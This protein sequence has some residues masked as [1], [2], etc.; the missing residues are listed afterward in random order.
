MQCNSHL[1]TCMPYS[2]LYTYYVE[3]C[4]R[5]QNKAGNVVYVYSLQIWIPY[6]IITFMDSSNITYHIFQH[7]KSSNEETSNKTS[8]EQS[9]H[10]QH[11]GFWTTL[12]ILEESLKMW[13]VHYSDGIHDFIKEN[14]CAGW[15]LTWDVNVRPLHCIGLAGD[16]KCHS[17]STHPCFN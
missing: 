10:R 16:C 4:N 17:I 1:H 12:V 15:G 11:T 8:L 9:H 2:L 5:W 3:I 6:N 7:K 14:G 13:L